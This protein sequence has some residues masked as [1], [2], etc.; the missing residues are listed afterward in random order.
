MHNE[1]RKTNMDERPAAGMF[2]AG[3][4]REFIPAAPSTH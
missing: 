3:N 2:I 1:N 4:Y